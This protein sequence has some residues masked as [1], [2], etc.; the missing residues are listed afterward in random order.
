M[1]M[2]F[3]E[4]VKDLRE[5]TKP[6]LV[7]NGINVSVKEDAPEEI[8]E[9]FEEYKRLANEEYNDAVNYFMGFDSK[10]KS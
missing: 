1:R 8:K 5:L 6:Y 4:K 9:A 10:P 3:S 2:Q 7:T